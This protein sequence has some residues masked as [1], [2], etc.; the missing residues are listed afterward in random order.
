MK[1]AVAVSLSAAMAFSLSAA[2]ALTASAA[3][4]VSMPK[5]AKVTVGKSKTLKVTT[6]KKWKVTK[7][8]VNQS[9]KYVTAKRLTNTKVRITGKKATSKAVTLRV[10]VKKKTGNKAEKVLK[11]KVTVKKAATPVDPTPVD[12]TPVDPTPVD[13]TPETKTHADVATQ[14]EL[15][16]ALADSNIKTIN[17]KTADKVD[18]VIPAGNHDVDLTV[19]AAA[20]SVVNN[21]TFKSIVINNISADTW[22]ENGENNSFTVNAKQAHF[23]FGAQA[24]IKQIL[25]K[26]QSSLRL[27]GT[28]NGKVPV[29]VEAE[30]SV[31]T[32]DTPIALEVKAAVS[33]TLGAAAKGSTIQATRGQKPFDINVTNNTGANIDITNEKGTK[34]ATAGQGTSKATAPVA[35]TTTPVDPSKPGTTT[36]ANKTDLGRY[37][38]QL[39]GAPTYNFNGGEI[40]TVSG[41]AIT[42]KTKTN[43]S[44]TLNFK[45]AKVYRANTSTNITTTPSAIK[46]ESNKDNHGTG[47]S[48]AINTGKI[49]NSLSEISG[50]SV[51]YKVDIYEGSNKIDSRTVDA[52]TDSEIVLKANAN[53]GESTEYTF[54]IYAFTKENDT[55]KEGSQRF[56]GLIKLKIERNIDVEK[57]IFKLSDTNGYEYTGVEKDIPSGSEDEQKY[58]FVD[59]SKN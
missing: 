32:S 37:Y 53:K 22:T 49:D 46:D 41:E 33:V 4:T 31:I 50:V 42:Y 56:V 17:I 12:P 34:I 59:P 5:T 21:A 35:D 40:E 9:K 11:C 15:D 57:P 18:F 2:T 48:E 26:L 44:I 43:P 58:I 1:K 39:A 13:P 27:E 28:P 19:D 16:A 38:M 52:G 47:K 7:V 36:P 45:E 23:K 30:N 10:R 3:T 25:V 55:Y 51:K 54:R 14:A 29:V 8:G 20:A 6:N 24:I